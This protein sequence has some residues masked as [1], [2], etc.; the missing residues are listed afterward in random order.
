MFFILPLVHSL[1]EMPI[2]VVLQ[3][4]CDGGDTNKL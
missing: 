1:R 2:I 4:Y 3:M